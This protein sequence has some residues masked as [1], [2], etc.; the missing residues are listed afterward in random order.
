MLPTLILPSPLTPRQDLLGRQVA[1]ALEHAALGELAG[2]TA[3]DTVLHG[4][5]VLVAGDFCFVE[6]AWVMLG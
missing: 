1:D 2:Y 3:V 6:F 4:V 5:N